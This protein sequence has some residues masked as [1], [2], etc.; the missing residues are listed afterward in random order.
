MEQLKEETLKSLLVNFN[1]DMNSK[2]VVPLSR[3]D[4]HKTTLTLT[5]GMLCVPML[6]PITI[7]ITTFTTHNIKI[8]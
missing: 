7:L 2:L 8:S 4:L 5:K 1:Q 6:A 3:N